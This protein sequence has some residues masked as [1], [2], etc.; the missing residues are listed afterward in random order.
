MRASARAL[1]MPEP[2]GCSAAWTERSFQAAAGKAP[3]DR[4]VI[5]V[6]SSAR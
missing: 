6:G 1:P 2:A 4:A 5:V 3:N